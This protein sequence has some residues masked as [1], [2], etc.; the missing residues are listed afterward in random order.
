MAGCASSCASR[1]QASPMLAI[2]KSKKNGEVPNFQEATLSGVRLSC[3]P[4]GCDLLRCPCRCPRLFVPSMSFRSWH[5]VG[6]H[7]QGL[8]LWCSCNSPLR[9][10]GLGT[11]VVTVNC[12]FVASQTTAALLF[13][14]AAVSAHIIACQIA[15]T[16]PLAPQL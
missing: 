11:L 10:Q 2:E 6:E 1:S 13:C 9:Y 12:D 16:L 15:Y 7:S 14:H 4:H 5:H 3:R 8:G